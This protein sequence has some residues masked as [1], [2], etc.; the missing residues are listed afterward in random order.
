[1]EV[2]VCGVALKQG[3]K[4]REVLGEDRSRKLVGVSVV[5]CQKLCPLFAHTGCGSHQIIIRL[6]TVVGIRHP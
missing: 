3:D 2:V 5:C 6:E 1:M 4:S